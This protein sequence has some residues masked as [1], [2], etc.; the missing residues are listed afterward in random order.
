M[1]CLLKLRNG[2]ELIEFGTCIGSI[3]N[4]DTG[5]SVTDEDDDDATATCVPIGDVV[6]L[7]CDWI[8]LD[9]VNGGFLIDDENAKPRRSV[10]LK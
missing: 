3:P 5:S 1:F 4:E 2:R 7:F 9:L 8:F 10:A 6:K